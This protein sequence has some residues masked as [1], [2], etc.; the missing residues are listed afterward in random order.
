MEQ[1]PNNKTEEKLISDYEITKNDFKRYFS[2]LMESN[3]SVFEQ[4]NELYKSKMG[5]ISQSDANVAIND[6][7][8][9]AIHSFIQN[10]F[11][12]IGSKLKEKLESIVEDYS[13]TVLNDLFDTLINLWIQKRRKKTKLFFISLEQ[14]YEVFYLLGFRIISSETLDKL[15]GAQQWDIISPYWL[16]YNFLRDYFNKLSSK[17]DV[18]KE[19]KNK[20][21]ILVELTRIRKQELDKKLNQYRTKEDFY[22]I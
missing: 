14:I 5:E 17:K 16:N 7:I 1:I 8:N 4:T 11:I 12:F 22:K 20:T 3:E 19:L 6:E 10:K 18:S 13:T 9:K 21:W 2:N 15:T